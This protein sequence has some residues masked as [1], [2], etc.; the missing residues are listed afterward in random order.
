MRSGLCKLPS[1]S[2]SRTS[3][4]LMSVKLSALLAICLLIA[5]PSWA[6]MRTGQQAITT[7]AAVGTKGGSGTRNTLTIK[8][9]NASTI[10]VL[11]GPATVTTSTGIEIC[12]GQAYTWHDPDLSGVS[13]A[14]DVIQC[15]SADGSSVSITYTET[16]Q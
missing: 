13:A 14:S 2:Y 10:C 5:T 3:A 11:C 4:I 1:D 12:G 9:K 8:N 16:Y 15:V 7:A 6:T